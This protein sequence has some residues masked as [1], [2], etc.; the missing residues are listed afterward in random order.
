ML[1][2]VRHLLIGNNQAKS[3]Y[4]VLDNPYDAA[5]FNGLEQHMQRYTVDQLVGLQPDAFKAQ[6][7]AFLSLE[8]YEMEQYV[9]PDLQRD[10]SIK[11][12]WGHDHDFGS[13]QLQG[14]MGQRHKGLLTQFMDGFE[15]TPKSF[16]GLRVLD[17]GTWTGGVSLLLASM[18][19]EVVALEEVTKYTD[20]LKYLCEAFDLQTIEVLNTSL[21]DLDDAVY[22]DSFD[23]VFYAGVIYHVTDPVLS[24][25]I[26]FNALKDGGICLLESATINHPKRILRY[27]GPERTWDGSETKENRRGWNW[28]VPSPNAMQQM[29]MDV[30][31]QNVDMALS[32]NFDRV[33]GVGQ[34]KS[35][36]DM[37]RAGL[38]R[39]TIR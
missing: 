36:V 12:H 2:R 27:E 1:N 19:A 26:V 20:T 21:Y 32:Y 29:M 34:R 22:A 35:H 14:L 4:R 33:V 37:L 38:A 30:G 5:T 13:F 18:G 7:D 39:P 24:L 17:I 23:V 3:S 8:D 28:F 11:F 31:F 25:R 10:L 9:S 16:E 6:I 15:L